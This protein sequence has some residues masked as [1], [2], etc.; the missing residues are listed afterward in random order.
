MMTVQ[1]QTEEKSIVGGLLSAL[2]L[3]AVL[4]APSRGEA[5][6]FMLITYGDD[7]SKV[8]DIPPQILENVKQSTGATS[9]EIGYKYSNF[10]IFFLNLWTWGGDYVIFENDT[11]W[12]LGAEG[13]AQMLG[14]D[15]GALKKPFTYSFPPGLIVLL[16]LV[17]VGAVYWIFTRNKESELSPEPAAAA[18]VDDEDD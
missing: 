17:V 7:I 4:L 12:D 13:A 16:L 5:K 10:G 14:V 6:G 8:A 3:G 18:Q 15:A 2:V 1:L 11:Y 9:P